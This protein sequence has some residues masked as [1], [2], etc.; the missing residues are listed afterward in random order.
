MNN[1]LPLLACL[2]G[3][4]FAAIGV[5][6]RLGQPRG[7]TPAHIM[8]WA[9]IV[10]IAFFAARTPPAT[11]AAAPRSVW[12]WAIIAGLGQYGCLHLAN[13]ALRLGPLS[14]CWCASNLTF[15]VTAV[16]AALFL[17]ERVTSLQCLGLA[18]GIGAVLAGVWSV[19][20][21]PAA[22]ARAAPGGL[23]RR[24][25]YALVLGLLLIL[26]SLA[27]IAIK[28]LN[29]N[30]LPGG[31]NAMDRFSGVFTT[32]FYV[33]F[34]LSMLTEIGVGG[35]WRRPDLPLVGLAALAAGGSIVGFL[36]WCY[37]AELPAAVLFT[38]SAITNIISAGLVSVT[39][40]RER[41]SAFWFLMMGLAVATV[42]LLR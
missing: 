10:A 37:C 22:G 38:L 5:A 27:P 35:R 23:G 2:A 16:V 41:A 42:L 18:T 9:A 39:L 25:E 15:L 7:I 32:V 33:S 40:F 20:P 24:L 17:N 31:G 1:A 4:C 34:W 30:P 21:A 11:W 36:L 12:T 14:P 29:H 19:P 8:F 28:A 6:Y 13:K 26:N 3:L